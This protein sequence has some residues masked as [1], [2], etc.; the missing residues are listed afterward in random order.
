MGVGL[1]Y[2]ATAIVFIARLPLISRRE[3]DPDEFEHAH[4]AWCVSKGMRLYKDF[5]EHHTPLYDYVL[6]PIFAGF[7]VDSSFESARHFLLFARGLS[8]VLAVIS[9]VLLSAIGRLFGDR[10]LGPLAGLLLVTQPI[11]LQKTIEIRPDVLALPLFLGGLWLVLRAM[12]NA[13]NRA[14][15]SLWL[16]V[17]GGICVGAA[18][19]STQKVLFVLPGMLAG[20]AIWSVFDKTASASPSPGRTFRIVLAVAFVVGV[21]LPAVLTWALFA[22]QNA[23]HEFVTNNF[24]L[25]VR[26]KPVATNQLLKLV[27]TSWP[28][29]VPA[30]IGIFHS[31]FLTVR[32]VFRDDRCDCRE[33]V[34]S[35]TTI[36]LFAGLA[37]M[38]SA[39]RQY[40]LLPLPLLC[41]FAAQT[42]FMLSD[43]LA[44]R[45]RSKVIV[46][47]T[48]ALG[49][50]PSIAM[51]EAFTEKNEA[52]L[53][54]LRSVYEMTKPTDLVMDGWEG[55]GVFRPHAFYYFFLHNE[56]VAMLPPARLAA[57]L[58][59]LESGRVRPRLIAL[60]EHLAALGP[61]F[62]T[63]VQGNYV[64]RDGFF[65][66]S[67]QQ[68]TK[69]ERHP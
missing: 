40:Y 44:I 7:D 51:A 21:A 41:L 49:V 5:F 34:L 43:R 35:C 50:L 61:R 55:T 20:L 57:Y 66:I 42:W 58:D 46:V 2:L 19:M 29:L 69:L 52:Q 3:F 31:I 8:F 36:G 60:D 28:I 48:I 38:P 9:V 59:D 54:R 45:V 37:V 62:L 67:K 32:R 6:R 15:R 10:R 63:F 30:I 17:A 53:A 39:H 27:T 11:F 26:W 22:L 47:V 16:F 33:L 56:T 13:S 4:A 25:N 12:A 65:Y 64:S 1:A 23:G 18:I 14:K 68:D 24:L